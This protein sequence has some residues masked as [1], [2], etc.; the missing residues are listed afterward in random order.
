MP[1]PVKTETPL[2]DE[3][4]KV[5]DTIAKPVTEAHDEQQTE[6]DEQPPVKSESKTKKSSVAKKVPVRHP[7]EFSYKQSGRVIICPV[8]N[9]QARCDINR[10]PICPTAVA[11][12]PRGTE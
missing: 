2:E 11:G 5:V 1:K 9:Q 10:I 3:T 7:A 4:V 8:C 6:D 12:C